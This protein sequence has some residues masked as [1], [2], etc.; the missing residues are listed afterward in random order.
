MSVEWNKHEVIVDG[1]TYKV[2]RWSNIPYYLIALYVAA[3]IW[4][5]FSERVEFDRATQ[6]AAK[7]GVTKEQ[8]RD[9]V[10]RRGLLPCYRRSH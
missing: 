7:Y 10:G 8:F 6:I 3:S 4:Q 1:V 9:F 5:C 2:R